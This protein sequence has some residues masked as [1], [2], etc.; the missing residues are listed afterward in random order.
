MLDVCTERPVAPTM[1]SSTC[2]N[3]NR[4]QGF[5]QA[6]P[7]LSGTTRGCCRREEAFVSGFRPKLP[8]ALKVSLWPL[9][10]P[11][12]PF[13]QHAEKCPELMAACHSS[14]SHALTVTCEKTR[15]K[16]RLSSLTP[17]PGTH[18]ARSCRIHTGAAQLKPLTSVCTG[19]PGPLVPM[20]LPVAGHVPQRRGSDSS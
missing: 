14:Y 20:A 15:V 9:Q 5:L 19:H 17:R 4:T 2:T 16:A 1:P 12:Q 10:V 3:K 6:R 7:C 13:C 18:A 11:T 8:F